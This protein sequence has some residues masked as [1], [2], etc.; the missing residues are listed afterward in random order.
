MNT[1]EWIA[2]RP[3]T[4]EEVSD[5]KRC[6]VTTHSG[7]VVSSYCGS[8]VR[9][10]WNN[11]RPT[12]P[13]AWMPMPERYQPSPKPAAGELWDHCRGGNVFIVGFSRD[14]SVVYQWFDTGSLKEIS[15]EEFPKHFTKLP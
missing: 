5:C 4:E 1:E 3:P 6:I 12:D 8:Y 14:G 7:T 15:P 11:V 10:C 13:I 9:D 2:S